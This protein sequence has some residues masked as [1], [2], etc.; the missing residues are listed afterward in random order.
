MSKKSYLHNFSTPVKLSDCPTD[1]PQGLDKDDLEDLTKDLA[2]QLGKLNEVLM[3][4]KKYSVLVVLQGMDGSGKD[5]AVENVFQFCT[6]SNL[7]TY[8]FKKPTENEFAHDFLWRVHKQ[9]PAKGEIG[10]FIRSHYED[11]LI[12]RVHKWIDENRVKKRLEAINAFEKLIEFD[13]NTIVCK[14]FLHISFEQQKEELMERKLEREKQWKH[15][16]N[17]WKEREHWDEYMRCYEDVINHSEI[18]W[19]IVPVDKRWYRDYVIT[20]TLVDKL[21]ALGMEY[22]SLSQE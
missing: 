16:Q 14:F 21:S 10:I 13:S 1:P 19:T 9:C 5:G 20:K 15:N 7:R 22:P 6:A 17:D 8:S 3:A 4:Q 18:P 2:K 11:V 12:Q